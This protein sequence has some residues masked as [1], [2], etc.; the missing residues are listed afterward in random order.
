MLRSF[1]R[2]RDHPANAVQSHL[3]QN[4][5]LAASAPL[6]VLK[7]LAC[8]AFLNNNVRQDTLMHYACEAF[9]NNVRIPDS[10]A[11]T[12][13]FLLFHKFLSTMQ[14]LTAYR[15]EWVIWGDEERL[16]GSVDFIAID[17]RGDLVIVDWKR[18]KGMKTTSAQAWGKT[19]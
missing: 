9:L 17:E 8:E 10:I 2:R 13:E 15:T 16:A 4:R 1:Q 7:C 14:G 11:S 6:N 12:T 5:L 18:S 19:T 3:A